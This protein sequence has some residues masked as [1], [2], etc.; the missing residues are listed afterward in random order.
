[1][2]NQSL[3]SVPP[4][5]ESPVVLQRF[6]SRLVEQLDVVLG[7]RSGPNDQYVSQQDLI[8]SA[9]NLTT[10]LRNAQLALEQALLRLDDVDKLIVE[11]LTKRIEDIEEKNT[12]QDNKLNLIESVVPVKGAMLAF[13]VDGLNEPNV[14]LKFNIKTNSSRISAGLYEFEIEQLT[15]KSVDIL[16]NSITTLS[17]VIAPS[18][19]SESYNVAFVST[20]TPGKFRIQVTVIEQG[21]GNKLTIV[22]YDLVIGDKV[23]LSALLNIPGTVL[24]SGL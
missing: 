18:A 8:D 17:W 9:E 7:N 3:V 6:L 14:L 15:F 23:S 4:N 22:P 1:M 20:A 19:V 24:P 2:T 5:V 21:V 13:T 12:Q 11:E 16:E 10:L